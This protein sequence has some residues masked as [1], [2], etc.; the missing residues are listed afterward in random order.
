MYITR[1]NWN[2]RL[3]IVLYRKGLKIKVQNT[4]ILMEDA[5]NIKELID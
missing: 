3:L 2:K 5:D 1:T 4:I